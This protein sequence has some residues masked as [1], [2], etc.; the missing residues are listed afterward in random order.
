MMI[1]TK[2]SIF[3]KHI[4]LTSYNVKLFPY[5]SLY[6]ASLILAEQTNSTIMKSRA[7]SHTIDSIK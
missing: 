5:Q 4:V 2:S 7:K 3:L 1:Y 6:L